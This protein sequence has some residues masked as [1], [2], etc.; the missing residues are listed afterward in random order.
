MS[1]GIRRV[2]LA[3]ALIVV[4]TLLALIIAGVI[5]IRDLIAPVAVPPP[6]LPPS[7][8]AIRTDWVYSILLPT[9]I[10]ECFTYA[11]NPGSIEKHAEARGGMALVVRFA[12]S[13]SANCRTTGHD[14]DLTLTEA[15]ALDS[16]QGTVTT[17]S[18]NRGQ[19]ARL[20]VPD[21][22]GRNRL[23]LQWH[24]ANIMCRL[25]GD[26]SAVLSEQDL[27]RMAESVRK[28]AT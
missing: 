20:T 6:A 27:L 12:P 7:L 21:E 2:S 13:G 22:R 17:L 18:G 1:Q 8:A 3:R 11:S 14:A 5:L 9:T 19:Y 23:I 15:P 16:L 10:P 25:G 28:V 26:T 4:A 24:C